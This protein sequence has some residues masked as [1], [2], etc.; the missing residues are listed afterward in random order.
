MRGLADALGWTDAATRLRFRLVN[1]LP[2]KLLG[3]HLVSLDRTRS[4][5]LEPPWPDLV[6]AMGRRTVPVARWIGEQSG[7]AV[8]LVQLGRKGANLADVFDLA[9][10]L[11]HFQ[12]PPHPA[13]LDLVVPPTQVTAARLAA[14]IVLV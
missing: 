9:V 2:N 14:R 8:K 1:H 6:V 12:L 5:P 10:A 7:G 3:A 13:R 4:D 11:R